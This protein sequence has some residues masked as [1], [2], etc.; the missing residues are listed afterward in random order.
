MYTNNWRDNNWSANRIKVL[1]SG[2]QR[3]WAQIEVL[4]SLPKNQET[5][6]HHGGDWEL[7]QAAQE[8]CGVCPWR[9][10]KATRVWSWATT[11]IVPARTGWVDQTTSGGYLPSLP[12]LVSVII[13]SWWNDFVSEKAKKCKSK[14]PQLFCPDFLTFQSICRSDAAEVQQ[15]YVEMKYEY[16]GDW[17]ILFLLHR[18]MEGKTLWMQ[19][20]NCTE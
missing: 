16:L 14:K 1:P 4:D 17:K 10:L 3:Q 9:Y 6:F 13:L 8:C 11:L 12:F 15:E 20:L 5:P 18:N 7:A 19:S 2:D